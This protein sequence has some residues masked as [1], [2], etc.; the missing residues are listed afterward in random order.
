M[1]ERVDERMKSCILPLYRSATQVGAEWGP[2]LDAVERPG[3]VLWGGK[4][5]YMGLEY[6]QRLAARTKAEIVV[7]EDVGHWWPVQGAERAAE[8]LEAFWAA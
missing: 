8:A 7:L 3:L 5:P 2:D 1:A 4:D 6:A